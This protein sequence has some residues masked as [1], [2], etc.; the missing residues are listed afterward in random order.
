MHELDATCH[1]I[2]QLTLG[3]ISEAMWMTPYIPE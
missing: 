2:E 1:E 3:E